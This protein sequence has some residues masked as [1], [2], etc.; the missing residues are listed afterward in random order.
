MAGTQSQ[1][2]RGARRSVL[3]ALMSTL[4]LAA[5]LAALPAP[6]SAAEKAIWG[7]TTLPDGASAFPLYRA[8][9][10][11]TYQI[12]VNWAAVAPSQPGSPTD[13]S[14]PAY[15]WPAELDRAVAEARGQRIDVAVLVSGSPAWANGGGPSIRAPAPGAFADFL[16][17]A[18]RRYGSVRRWMIWGEPNRDDRFQPSG[19]PTAARAYAPLLD[20]A[21]VAL[22]RVSRANRVI[23]GMTWTGGSVTPAR[24]LRG[25]RM[26]DG[27]PP[28]LDWFGH[29]PF[30]F[31]FPNLAEIPVAEGFRDISDLDTFT[32]EINR[33][34]KRPCRR[35]GKRL[36]RGSCDRRPRLWLSEYTVLS[37]R[38]SST[39]RLSVSRGGQARYLRASYRIADRLDSV[40]GL[41]WFQLLDEVPGPGSSNWG[42]LTADGQPKPAL[43]AFERAP[44]E[45]RAPGVRAT[46][47]LSRR[48]AARR[49]I[50]VRVRPRASGRVR[51]ELRRAG[52]RRIVRATRRGRAGRRLGLRFRR[53]L[54]PG[55]YVVVVD[56]PRGS[57]VTRRVALRRG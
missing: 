31:R 13:P 50:V 27:R 45:R 52:G 8:L 39:F 16:T 25:L 30:P 38:S 48:A 15:R 49:G 3:A 23:G 41:G 55:R 29:N 1:A 12:S 2:A 17:A 43:R 46:R 34:Y 5:L 47:R 20:A 37:D 56:A 32:R 10:V 24:F 51:I 6:A 54:R 7:P 14:D 18:S 28:R 40:A 36:P 21:Y 42:L 53:A 57:R 33:V 11:D 26:P 22:K 9:G 4:A 19:D 44:S 35:R